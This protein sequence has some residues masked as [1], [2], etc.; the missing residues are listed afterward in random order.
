MATRADGTMVGAFLRI[1]RRCADAHGAPNYVLLPGYQR[2]LCLAAVS[3]FDLLME[4]VAGVTPLVSH[5]YQCS[6][7]S[8]SVMHH[9]WLSR[10]CIP[11]WDSQVTTLYGD[12]EALFTGESWICGVYCE[13]FK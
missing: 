2:L 4:C 1:V 9:L 8:C 10:M 5:A 11:A 6:V 7:V 3:S 12:T 13:K